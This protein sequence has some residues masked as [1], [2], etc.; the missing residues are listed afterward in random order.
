MQIFF[1]YNNF[2]SSYNLLFTQS[3]ANT[4]FVCGEAYPRVY[5]S[6]VWSPCRQTQIRRI[7]KI[8]NKH[9]LFRSIFPHI[10]FPDPFTNHTNCVLISSTLSLTTLTA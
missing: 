7:E 2:A 5:A 10:G 9:K 4:L 6:N 3:F 1:Y 8:H